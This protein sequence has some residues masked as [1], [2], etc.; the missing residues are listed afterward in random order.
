LKIAA[1]YWEICPN[2]DIGDIDDG[3]YYYYYYYHH[4]H[5]HHHHRRRRHLHSE[6][7]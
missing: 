1:V 5:H 3:A 2:P 6:K 4:H 7:C